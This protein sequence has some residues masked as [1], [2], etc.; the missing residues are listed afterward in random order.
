MLFW[1][2]GFEVFI[3]FILISPM[4]SFFGIRGIA[5]IVTLSSAMAC[6]IAYYLLNKIIS[7]KYYEIFTALKP[8]LIAV[9]MMVAGITGL[10]VLLKHI[11]IFQFIPLNLVVLSLFAIVIYGL[12][13]YK[14]EKTYIKEM[15]SWLF[16]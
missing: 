6:F 13:I 1:L 12:V 11:I 8:S 14:F 16:T 7:I 3:F 5:A 15:K 10:K 2:A 4:A 9:T